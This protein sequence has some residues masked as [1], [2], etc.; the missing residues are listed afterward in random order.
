MV[1]LASVADFFSGLDGQIVQWMET[2][3]AWV[4]LVLFAVIFLET[5][6]FFGGPLPG[7]TLV[8]SAGAACAAGYLDGWATVSLIYLASVLGYFFNYGWGYAIG[9]WFVKKEAHPHWLD[10]KYMGKARAFFRN[11]ARASIVFARFI[12]F[13]RSFA[14]PTAGLARMPL[15]TFSWCNILGGAIWSG[16]YFCVGYGVTDVAVLSGRYWLIPLGILALFVPA[17]A[18]NRFFNTRQSAGIGKNPDKR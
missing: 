12:P 8:V 4:Y 15:G 18:I 5:N 10:N 6:V 7:D 11:H 2:Y 16:V 13:M 1:F 17:W 9:V 14:P 3:G